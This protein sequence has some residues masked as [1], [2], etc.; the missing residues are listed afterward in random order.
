MYS[1]VVHEALVLHLT[2]YIGFLE[3]YVTQLNL[4]KFKLNMQYQRSNLTGG[5]TFVG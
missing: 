4:L 1:N 2:E 5:L 3:R